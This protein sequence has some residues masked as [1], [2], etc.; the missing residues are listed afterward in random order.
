MSAA[1]IAA[2]RGITIG[3]SGSSRRSLDALAKLVRSAGTWDTLVLSEHANLELLDGLVSDHEACTRYR[4][5]L[6]HLKALVVIGGGAPPAVPAHCWFRRIPSATTMGALLKELLGP[7][8]RSEFSEEESPSV[9]WWRK[10]DM[11]IGVSTAIRQLMRLLDRL[12]PSAAPVIIFGESGS[13]KE[14]VARAL[15]FCGPR[16]KM[17]FISVNCAAIPEPLFES[18]LFGYE[19]GAFTGAHGARPGAFEAAD[20]GTL[21]LDEIGE[22]PRPLQAK[23]LR[24]LDRGEVTRL[25]STTPRRVSVRVIAATNRDLDSAVAGGTFREDLYYRLRVC[26]VQVP[27]LRERPEDIAPITTHYLSLIAARE[28][29]TGYRI[30]QGALERLLSQPWPGNVRELVNALERAWLL[31]KNGVITEEHIPPTAEAASAWTPYGPLRAYREAKVDF[32]AHYYSRLMR[33]CGGNVSMAARI[34][35]KTRREVY[36]ALRRLHLEAPDYRPQTND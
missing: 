18:E 20:G 1:P 5:D 13:G 36:S 26:M 8:P 31:A 35:Q 15:H 19:R 3:L 10:S 32:E 7:P 22:L 14:L 34:S 28:K 24:V 9:S 23:L 29:R 2:S 30:T 33:A 25:G 6:A 27:P 16:A 11:I 17:P 12:A 21:L 4:S